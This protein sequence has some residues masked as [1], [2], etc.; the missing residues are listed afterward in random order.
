MLMTQDVGWLLK[1]RAMGTDATSWRH[2]PTNHIDHQTSSNQSYWPTN[3]FHPITRTTKQTIILAIIIRLGMFRHL[4]ENVSVASLSSLCN[5][6]S[7]QWRREQSMEMG[8][9]C[10]CICPRPGSDTGTH[11][12]RSTPTH[13]G[14]AGYYHYSGSRSA[15]DGHFIQR[16]LQHRPIFL[17]SQSR[18]HLIKPRVSFNICPFV[19]STSGHFIMSWVQLPLKGREKSNLFFGQICWDLP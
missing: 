10:I 3:I 1:W 13:P 4:V 14:L 15:A 9:G 19:F 5:H 7:H 17:N 16:N 2:L 18:Q 12:Q 11:T 8:K 6:A